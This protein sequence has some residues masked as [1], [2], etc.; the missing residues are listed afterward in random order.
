M[1]Q[2]LLD[3]GTAVAQATIRVANLLSP[4]QKLATAEGDADLGLLLT[5]WKADLED[6]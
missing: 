1:R 2:E 6:L 3:N 4:V 5:R